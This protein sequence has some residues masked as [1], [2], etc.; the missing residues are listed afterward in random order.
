MALARIKTWVAGDTLTAADLNA[1]FNNLLNNALSL[2][3]PLTGQLVMSTG[4]V[5]APSIGA[6]ADLNTGLLSTAADTLSLATGGASY[7]VVS[8]NQTF[9]STGGTA[10]LPGIALLGDT[11]TGI[12]S[13]AADTIGFV[14]AG[15]T[16]LV[17]SSASIAPAANLAIV[18][19]AVSGVPAQ[20][21]LYRENVVKGWAKIDTGGVVSD[22]YNVSSVTDVGV[23]R[24]NVFWD[25]DFV[26][27]VYASFVCPQSAGA[28]GTPVWGAVS[29]T[30]APNVGSIEAN[31]YTS[32]GLTDP[33]Y[34]YV[35]AIGDQ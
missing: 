4:S 22:S 23:G 31:T 30:D 3:S 27:T 19:A 2:I 1:E 10:A 35:L 12:A 32:T 6:N 29:N 5:G 18:P 21:G 20:H 33:N 15:V 25:R 13:T 34:T 24:A 16:Q 14:A 17:V 9:V 8:S 7:V 26:N 28:A 11:N